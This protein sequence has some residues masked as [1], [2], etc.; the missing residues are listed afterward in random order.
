M[1]ARESSSGACTA[2]SMHSESSSQSIRTDHG[3]I[4]CLTK[5]NSQMSELSGNFA[6]LESRV[7]S[8]EENFNAK[9]TVLQKQMARVEVNLKHRKRPE[10]DGE[11]FES[12]IAAIPSLSDI[13]LGELNLPIGDVDG[14]WELEQKLTDKN[15][16][17]NMVKKN[18]KFI[19]LIASFVRTESSMDNHSWYILIVYIFIYSSM[20]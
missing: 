1:N 14:L 10:E 13:N 4:Q 6:S 15:F 16:A 2:V 18:R 5:L 8:F 20:R 7:K 12:R 17:S 11:A 9:I 19:S 3:L